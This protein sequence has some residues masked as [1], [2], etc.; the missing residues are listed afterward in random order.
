MA[1]TSNAHKSAGK[2]VGNTRH[3]ASRARNTNA[4]FD[5][6]ESKFELERRWLAEHAEAIRAEN[7]YI[8]THGLPLAKYRLF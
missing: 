5:V 4:E 2:P 8:E 6:Q 1:M 7:E 3:L